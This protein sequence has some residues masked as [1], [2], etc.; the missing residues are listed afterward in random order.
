MR[1]QGAAGDI[2]QRLV[3][4][5]QR[6]GLQSGV[7]IDCDTAGAPA[8]LDPETG[9]HLLLVVREALNNAVRHGRPGRV[10]VRLQGENGGLRLRVRDDGC[11][12]DPGAV[13]RPGAAHYGIVGMRERIESLGGSFVLES[14]PG[15]GTAIEIVLP[16][17]ARKPHRAEPVEKHG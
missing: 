13:S 17:D 5:A 12:F 14:A 1:S 6:I 15:R 11:G 8:A 7:P 9:H 2:G 4:I 10:S 3:E 16:P